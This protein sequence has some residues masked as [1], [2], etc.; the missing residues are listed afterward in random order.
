M[1][2]RLADDTALCRTGHKRNAV[3]SRSID[4][5]KVACLEHLAGGDVVRHGK[6]GAK[7]RRTQIELSEAERAHCEGATPVSWFIFSQDE[8]NTPHRVDELDG[9][10]LVHLLP[11]ARDMDVNYVVERR[12]SGWLLPYV[13]G[14]HLP[15]YKV[16]LVA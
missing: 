11:Q 6:D 1:R 7:A 14:E 13:T 15:G 2:G 10:V 3:V 8:A 12:G 4:D 16:V 9:K 5:P